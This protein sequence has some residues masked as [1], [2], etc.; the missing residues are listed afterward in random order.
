MRLIRI[1]FY[2]VLTQNTVIKLVKLKLD[3]TEL[4]NFQMIIEELLLNST[5]EI[6]TL[7]HTLGEWRLGREKETQV[8][9]KKF[10]LYIKM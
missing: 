9:S 8:H 3:A 2:F 4:K 6:L 1:F 5:S 10:K 7:D